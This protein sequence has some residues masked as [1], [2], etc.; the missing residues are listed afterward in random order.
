MTAMIVALVLAS[1]CAA[2]PFAFV[3]L[4]RFDGP[5]DAWF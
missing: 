3:W 2:S 1:A 4:S 5:D